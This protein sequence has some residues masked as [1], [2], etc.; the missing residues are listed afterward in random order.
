MLKHSI[1][2][3]TDKY[4]K[5]FDLLEPVSFIYNNNSFYNLG[6]SQRTHIGFIANSIEESLENS[7]LT[8]QEFAGYILQEKNSELENGT[9]FLRYEEFIALNT[10]QIQKLKSRVTELETQLEELKS[11]IN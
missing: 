1:L 11:K 5:F 8:T 2:L 10:W 4:E 7:G 3:L 6:T 9:R